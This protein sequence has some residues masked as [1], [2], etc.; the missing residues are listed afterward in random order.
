MSS[1]SQCLL[2]HGEELLY[3][4]WAF[5]QVIRVSVRSTM[6]TNWKQWTDY[7]WTRKKWFVK[8]SRGHLFVSFSFFFYTG[9]VLFPFHFQIKIEVLCILSRLKGKQRHCKTFHSKFTLLSLSL[10]YSN[11]GSKK[12]KYFFFQKVVQT[13]RY[14]ACRLYFW[15]A[16]LLALFVN[17]MM[18]VNLTNTSRE[19]TIRS[20]DAVLKTEAGHSAVLCNA[21]TYSTGRQ[22]CESCDIWKI[23]K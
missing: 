12:K 23:N 3:L 11:T 21:L 1:S 18:M 9:H 20:N 4:R 14:S 15:F 2:P 13:E 10:K 5:E 7:K 17:G 19:P 8:L 16:S 6:T 22:Q